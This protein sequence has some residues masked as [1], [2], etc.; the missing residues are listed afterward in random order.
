MRAQFRA[1]LKTQAFSLPEMLA[2]ITILGILTG[3]GIANYGGVNTNVREKIAN[4][5]CEQM[6]SAL[7]SFSQSS[8]ELSQTKDDTKIDDELAVLR[9]LQWRD[10]VAP[11][12]GSPFLWPNYNPS[13]SSDTSKLRIQWNGSVFKLLKVNQTGNGLLFDFERKDFTTNYVFPADYAPVAP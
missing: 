1:R 5:R 4:E 3:I 8:Y 13:G 10:P 11:D 7:K 2:T 6:N 12:P 9:S